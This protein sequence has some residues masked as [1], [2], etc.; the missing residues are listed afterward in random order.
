MTGA[1]D[2]VAQPLAIKL[3]SKYGKAIT[4]QRQGAGTYDVAT[5]KN[6]TAPP[7]P[8]AINAVIE[9]YK[10]YAFANGLAIQGDKKASVAAQGLAVPTPGDQI[11]IDSV[12]FSIVQVETV[13]SGELAA[14]YILQGRVK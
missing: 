3:I 2:A 6:T 13:Y 11:I 1:L 14:M 5:G 4:L 9:D 8:E 10:P 12:T 7:S